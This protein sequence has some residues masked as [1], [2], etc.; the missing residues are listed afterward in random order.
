[1]SFW[2][3][4]DEKLTVILVIVWSSALAGDWY[5]VEGDNWVLFELG[6]RGLQ[7]HMGIKTNS[8]DF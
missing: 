1:M 6:V 3:K 2:K 4:I 8:T 5:R 7:S